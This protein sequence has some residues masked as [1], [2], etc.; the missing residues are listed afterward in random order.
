M[1]RTLQF[2]YA[3]KTD[4]VTAIMLNLYENMDPGQVSFD[5]LVGDEKVP[6]EIRKRIEE[7]GGRIY[8]IAAACRE[9]NR[10]AYTLHKVAFCY[11]LMRENHYDLVHVHTENAGRSLILI[12][13]G[14]AGVRGRI[15]H[16]HSAFTQSGKKVARK[17]RILKQLMPLWTNGYLTCS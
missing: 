4:G 3:L 13:A 6:P 2:K 16:S 15:L 1:I 17:Q 11:R 5:F 9:K 8:S 12:F 10:L 7:R 14:L